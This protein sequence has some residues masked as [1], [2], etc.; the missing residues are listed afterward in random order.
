M[1]YITFLIYAILLANSARAQLIVDYYRKRV[2]IKYATTPITINAIISDW[3]F[4][5]SLV[6]QDW[7]KRGNKDNRV[8]VKIAW[9]KQKLYLA[10]KVWDTELNARYSMAKQPVWEDDC[11]ELYLS[12]KPHQ[13]LEHE[14]TANDYQ[15]VVNI[16]NVSSIIS[17]GNIYSTEGKNFNL[18][19]DVF[20]D[21]KTTGTINDNSDI[22]SGYI[23]EMAIN[24]AS[25]GYIPKAN[26]TLLFD[27]CVEDRDDSLKI[28]PFDF[29]FIPSHFSQ[30]KYW[31]KLILQ[32]DSI[33]AYKA[34][35]KA[36]LVDNKV[37]HPF[38]I[39]IV[40]GSIA[41]LFSLLLLFILKRRKNT[42][43]LGNNSSFIETIN[44]FGR[45]NNSKHYNEITKKTF[46]II[47][48]GYKNELKTSEVAAQLNISERHL[49]RI[50]KDT[51]KKK[52]TQHLNEFRIIKA[53]ELLENESLAISEIV[54][55]VGFQNYSHFIKVFKLFYNGISPKV[56]REQNRHLSS[57]KTT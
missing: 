9:D 10:Y 53:T 46:I 2:F 5:D 27:L 42:L 39:W 34:I 30:P 26:D 18:E 50:L 12:T 37:R 21:V 35:N 52:F 22:D 6:F 54:Y 24:W 4:P 51:T 49:Q 7:H 20:T 25:L 48:K 23:V 1:R 55:K 43:M 19:T 16:N 38:I 40:V 17:G 57:R 41:L 8:S 31:W 29:A 13:I 33:P 44:N 11:V 3:G 45:P 56:F 36:A 28:Y 14:L 32:N 15:F 47:E